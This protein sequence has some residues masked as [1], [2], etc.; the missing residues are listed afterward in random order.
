MS[1]AMSIR[2]AEYTQ[3]VKPSS[4]SIWQPTWRLAGPEQ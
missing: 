4:Q 1:V 3:T 2:Q